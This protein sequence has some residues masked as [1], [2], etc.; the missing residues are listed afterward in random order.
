MTG[1]VWTR[2]SHCAKI[3]R[4]LIRRRSAREAGHISEP[5]HTDQMGIAALWR[6]KLRSEKKEAVAAG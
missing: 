2:L 6:G 5:A 1:G 3:H 4:V